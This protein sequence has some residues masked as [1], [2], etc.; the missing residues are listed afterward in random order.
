MTTI[1][2]GALGHRQDQEDDGSHVT[3]EFT[4]ALEGPEGLDWASMGLWADVAVRSDPERVERTV[5]ALVHALNQERTTARRSKR[6][7]RIR[8]IAAIVTIVSAIAVTFP[9]LAEGSSKDGKP[10]VL[11]S[12][13]A[14]LIGLSASLAAT[15]ISAIFVGRQARRERDVIKRVL[16]Y[17][18]QRLTDQDSLSMQWKTRHQPPQQ[19]NHHQKA[20]GSNRNSTGRAAAGFR[21][22]STS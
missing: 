5:S 14:V 12:A 8:L 11:G 4:D 9:L 18:R 15:A 3:G 2:E 20:V 7:F 16:E 21:R 6:E 1:G 22:S 17:Q 10:I 13:L 19:F